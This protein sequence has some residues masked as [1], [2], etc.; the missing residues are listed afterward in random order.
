MSISARLGLPLVAAGQSQKEVTHNEAL[1]LLDSISQATCEGAPGNDPPASPAI[2]S[3]YL[4]GAVPTGTWSGNSKALATWTD[5]GWRFA[6][7]FEGMSAVERGSGVLW[8]FRD[9]QWVRGK[10]V[11]EEMQV[12]SDRVVGPRLSA[13][14]DPTGGSLVDNETR[15]AVLQIL[16]RLREHGLIAS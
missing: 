1:L 14:A 6:P 13:V 15:Q 9:D 8:S 5:Y 3:S 11:C 12:G 2:G 16:A 7:A 10:I 4:C